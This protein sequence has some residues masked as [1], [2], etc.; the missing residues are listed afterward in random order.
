MTNQTRRKILIAF[1]IIY[2]LLLLFSVFVIEK[3]AEDSWIWNVIDIVLGILML[4]SIPIISKMVNMRIE[5]RHNHTTM[6]NERLVFNGKPKFWRLFIFMTG[7][8]MLFVCFAIILI[9][10]DKYELIYTNE[11]IRSLFYVSLIV[12]PF[13]FGI[14]KF[15]TLYRCYK[16]TYT[17]EGGNLIVDEWT[18]F[19]KKTDH[20]LIPINEI[21][22]LSKSVQGALPI[23]N[24][25][26]K[27]GGVKRELETGVVGE[28][29]YEALKERMV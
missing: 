28:D 17:I 11:S 16:N 7:M 29:L 27:V 20:L 23:T 26:I 1:W 9:F 10:H 24:L 14:Y 5:N 22:A 15:N 19:R 12:F 8:M 18:I 13:F 21:E 4:A 2:D 25:K 6:P 3:W